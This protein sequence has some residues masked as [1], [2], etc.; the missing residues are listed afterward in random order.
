MTRAPRDSSFSAVVTGA[1]LL[2][3]TIACTAGLFLGLHDAPVERELRMSQKIF[4]FHAPLGIWA[5]VLMLVA[6]GAGV[7]YLV[8]R[9]PLADLLSE[10]AFE[11]VVVAC[12]IV[13]VTGSLWARPAWNE[14][15]PWNEP[16][17]L[18]VLLLFLIGLV[19]LAV[20]SSFDEPQLKARLSA[21]VAAFGAVD[22]VV[23]YYAVTI[24]NSMHPRVITGGGMALHPAMKR[25]FLVCVVGVGLVVFGLVQARWR[26]A[27]LRRAVDEVEDR[28]AELGLE[29]A[30]P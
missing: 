5:I 27:R 30:R 18:T 8:T 10:A 24:W 1:A 9:N 19:Y 17:V 22:A 26:L 2:V 12:A 16:R 21:V 23:A 14:W 11:V 4:Y 13:L 6:V 29:G 28:A 20:R 25:A 7:W 15:F 3:G